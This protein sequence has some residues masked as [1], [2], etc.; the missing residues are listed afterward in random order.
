V[1]VLNFSDEPAEA[2]FRL[3]PEFQWLGQG[4][5]LYDLLA[6]ALVPITPGAFTRVMVPA[7]G[8]RLLTRP[9]GQ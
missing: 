6:E 7:F 2:G 5:A 4:E 3:G 8:A 1:V 9:A